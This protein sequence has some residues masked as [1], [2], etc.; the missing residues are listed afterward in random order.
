MK[1]L[2][3]MVKE[4]AVVAGMMAAAAGVFAGSLALAGR[5]QVRAYDLDSDG[6]KEYLCR[7]SAS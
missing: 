4:G 1:T 3:Q 7:T 6:K 2:V 5:L